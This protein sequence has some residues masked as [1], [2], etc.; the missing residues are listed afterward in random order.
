MEQPL[1]LSV[2]G[3]SGAVEVTLSLNAQDP[4]Q[5]GNGYGTD[6]HSTVR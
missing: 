3:V 4:G 2:V 1:T 6:S 5:Y